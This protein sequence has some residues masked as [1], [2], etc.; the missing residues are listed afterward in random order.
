LSL[1]NDLS[2]SQQEVAGLKST[3]AQMSAAQAGIEAELS[4]TKVNTVVLAV[5]YRIRT[6]I[7]YL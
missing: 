7:M 1:E 4:A 5:G 6:W 3:V 2:A